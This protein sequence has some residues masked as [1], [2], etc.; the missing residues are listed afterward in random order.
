MRYILIILT[1]IYATSCC[2]KPADRFAEING[3]KLHILERGTGDPVV[4]FLT[5]RIGPLEHF[6]TVQSQISKETKTFSY[7]RSGLGLSEILDTIRTYDHVAKELNSLLTHENLKPPYIL[8]AHSFGG[9][10]AREFYNQFPEKVAGFVFVDC[11]NDEI[12][13]DSLLQKQFITEKFFGPDSL[14]TPGERHEMIYEKQN[15]FWFKDDFTT[16]LPAHLLVAS[17]KRVGL[18][19]EIMSVKINTYKQFNRGAPQMKIIFTEHSGHNIQKDQPELV[20]KSIKEIIN[21]VRKP[22]K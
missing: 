14:A 18:P 16:T 6:Y 2:E 11:A 21:E 1:L 20:I 9:G 5:G 8:V 15:T 7:D 13:F 4:V 17:G 22:S 19:D 10:T 12:F 3:K